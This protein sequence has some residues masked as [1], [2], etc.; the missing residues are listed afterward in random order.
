MI[1][2]AMNVGLVILNKK[3]FLNEILVNEKHFLN[4]KHFVDS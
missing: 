3:H 2:N 4:E 1:L